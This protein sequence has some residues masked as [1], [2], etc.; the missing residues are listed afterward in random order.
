VGSVLV[1]RR[2]ASSARHV[3]LAAC[4]WDPALAD[5]ASLPA[6][7]APISSRPACGLAPQRSQTGGGQAATCSE[8]QRMAAK[9]IQRKVTTLAHS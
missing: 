5:A 4:D 2:S 9:E 1:S 7:E 6:A 8:T 3:S